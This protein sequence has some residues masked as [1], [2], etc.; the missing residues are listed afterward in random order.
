MQDGAAAQRFGTEREMRGWLETEE[1][2]G[3]EGAHEIAERDAD[4]DVRGVE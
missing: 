1:R 2:L 4:Q 3:E